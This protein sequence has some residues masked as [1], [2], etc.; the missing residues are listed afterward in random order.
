MDDNCYNCKKGGDGG[1]DH[2]KRKITVKDKNGNYYAVSKDDPRYLSGELLPRAKGLITV[3]DKNNNQFQISKDDPRYLSGE[4]ISILS[5]HIMVRDKNNKCFLVDKD[6]PRYISGELVHN[7]LGF[8]PVKDKNGN[9]FSV[10]KDDPRYLSGEVVS[11]QKDKHH[12][13][14]TRNKIRNSMIQDNSTNPR[15]W[16]SKDGK[17]KYIL[18]IKLHEYLNDGWEL[19]RINCNSHINTQ[20]KDTL[21][22]NKNNKT[23]KNNKKQ[24]TIPIYISL[25]S[26]DQ[27]QILLDNGYNKTQIAKEFNISRSKVNNL[28]KY[29]NLQYIKSNPLDNYTYEQYLSEINSGMSKEAIGRKYG[30]SSNAINH[31][32]K[33]LIKK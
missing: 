23:N 9:I 27:I 7:C 20:D 24:K 32:I 4:L 30:V 3:K 15:I 12:T 21:I 25:I 5:N 17:T 22:K 28:L 13:I 6:D 31:K 33:N 26:K 2:M 11:I 14:E 16:V 1:W 18:K 19:G 8:V 10:K 29:Y